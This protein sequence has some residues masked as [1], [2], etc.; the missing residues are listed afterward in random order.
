MGMLSNYLFTNMFCIVN[1]YFGMH[2]DVVQFPC[3]DP[4]AVG[5]SDIAILKYILRINGIY[6]SE[7]SLH[8]D[9]YSS[10]FA[11]QINFS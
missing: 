3:R 6:N 2:L 8:I 11:R 7:P 9:G 10:T 5:N 4:V 1:P